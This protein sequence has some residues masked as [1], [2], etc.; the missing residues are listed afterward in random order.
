V[1]DAFGTAH[2]AHAST[3]GVAAVLPRHAAG[4]LMAAELQHLQSVRDPA[5]PLLVLLG[6][7]KVSDKIAVLEALAPHAEV[8]AIGGAMAYTFLAARGEPIGDS[9]YEADCVEDA[10]RVEYAAAKHGRRLLLPVDHIVAESLEPDAA[11]RVVASIPDGWIGLDVGPETA[12]AYVAEAEAAR[13]I[14]WNGPMGMF[15][16]PA[17]A[18]GTRA[19]ATGLAACSGTTVIGGGDSVAAVNQ[20]GVGDRID[21]LSTGGGASLEYVQGLTLPGI[22]AL[23]A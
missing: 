10:R 15:E 6:G 19:V 12:R 11:T 13:T 21:H 23:E 4:D 14:F 8:L 9:L 16:V 20:M 7:A 2:R 5:R 18:V 1:N 17:Y 22:A 3:V